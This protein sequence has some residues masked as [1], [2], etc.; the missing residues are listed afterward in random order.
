[1]KNVYK[2]IVKEIQQNIARNE[3]RFEVFLWNLRRRKKNEKQNIW[4]KGG[5]VFFKSIS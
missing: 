2:N 1:M 5:G 3:N 4:K